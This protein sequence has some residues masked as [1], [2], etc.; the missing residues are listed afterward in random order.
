MRSRWAPA[1]LP[2]SSTSGS[3]QS[4]R[5]RAQ[6]ASSSSV[7]AGP[8]HGAQVV[9]EHD[10]DRGSRTDRCPARR[11][12]RRRGGPASALVGRA[13]RVADAVAAEV[14]EPVEHADVAAGAGDATAPAPRG[15]AAARCARR[16]GRLRIVAPAGQ[17]V[18]RAVGAEAHVHGDDHRHGERHD[19]TAALPGEA[20][21]QQLARRCGPGRRRRPPARSSSAAGWRRPRARPSARPRRRRTRRWPRRRCPRGWCPGARPTT[22][23]EREELVAVGALGGHRPAVAVAVDV[24]HVDREAERALA[25]RVVEQRRAAGPA[26]RASEGRSLAVLAQH[27]AAQRRVADEEAGVH[28]QAAV[29]RVEVL[30]EVAPGPVGRPARAPRAACPRPWPACART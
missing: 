6:W 29:E 21:R 27:E 3:S 22:V 5:R 30:A 1:S 8:Q 13:V 9:G 19:A 24:G 12:C 18:Q 16:A 14:G 10:V 20:G 26:R 28:R 23:A 15:R 4:S 17:E 7:G 25:E 11:R 2:P